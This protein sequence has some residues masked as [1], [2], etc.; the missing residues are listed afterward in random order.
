M[1]LHFFIFL[2]IIIIVNVWVGGNMISCFHF[3]K[4]NLNNFVHP[5][6]MCRWW[7]VAWMWMQSQRLSMPTAFLSTAFHR[8]VSVAGCPVL[9]AQ[10]WTH[11]SL[12]LTLHSPSPLAPMG[13]GHE[14]TCPWILTLREKT[15]LATPAA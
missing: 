4:K 3:H 8:M 10:G 15:L 11:H 13:C 1:G 6:P 9:A 12:H 2:F 7:T 14:K 5:N